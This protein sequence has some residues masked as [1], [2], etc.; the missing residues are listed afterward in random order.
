MDDIRESI[1]HIDVWVCLVMLPVFS[2][3]FRRLLFYN[4]VVLQV[5]TVL[6]NLGGVAHVVDAAS[7]G[8]TKSALISTFRLQTFEA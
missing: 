6:L 3:R 1:K 2:Q 8:Y 7:A 4:L 5:M